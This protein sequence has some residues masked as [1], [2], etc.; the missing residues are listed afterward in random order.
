MRHWVHGGVAVI[1]AVALGACGPSRPNQPAEPLVLTE[2][3]SGRA[4]TISAGQ[5][6]TVRLA[7]NPTTGYRWA[8]VASNEGVVQ[9]LA[10]PAFIRDESHPG[11]VGVGGVEVFR[12]RGV[13]SGH[14]TLSLEY[15]RPWEDPTLP[16]RAVSYQIAVR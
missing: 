5:E 11:A 3:D 7:S 14:Q 15:R 16:A 12:F 1:V 6:I 2:N 8:L 13:R 4:V 10:E 9:A